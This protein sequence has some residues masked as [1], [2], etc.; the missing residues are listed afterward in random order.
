MRRAFRAGLA[1]ICFVVFSLASWGQQEVFVPGKG[2]AG[3]S[4]IPSEDS[5]EK[6]PS[7]YEGQTHKYTQTSTGNTPATEG[8][9]FVNKIK[10]GNEIKICPKAD[11]TSEGDGEFSASVEYSDKQGNTGHIAMDAKAKYKGKVGVESK[12][13]PPPAPR[14]PSR[15]GQKPGGDGEFNL[16]THFH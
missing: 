14:S 4:L 11:G 12:L 2:D 1:A 5:T 9:V 13:D 3:Y 7:G 16:R 8:K 6:A 15:D 10:L